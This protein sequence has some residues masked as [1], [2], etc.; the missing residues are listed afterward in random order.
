M[1][2]TEPSLATDDCFSNSR[3]TQ[4]GSHKKAAA[5]QR[6]TKDLVRATPPPSLLLLLLLV[7]LLSLFPSVCLSPYENNQWL[8]ALVI[9]FPKHHKE[10]IKATNAGRK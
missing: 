3:K 2:E 9:S 10:T 8:D 7:S 6:E 5:Y 1:Q 4:L